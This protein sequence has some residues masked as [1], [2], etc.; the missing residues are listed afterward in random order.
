MHHRKTFICINF[1]HYWVSRSVK[2]VHTNLFAKNWKLHKFAIFQLE[3]R[4]ITPFGHA[5]PPTDI[6]ADVEINRPIR[7][8]INAKINYFHR[9]SD[10]Q[11]DGR[12]DVAYDNR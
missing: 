2:T 9:R 1:Q 12:T 10:A 11:T 7:Y 6:Q 3:F 5:L 4:N 8:Q